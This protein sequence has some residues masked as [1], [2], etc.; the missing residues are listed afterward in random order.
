MN[1][2][3][4]FEKAIDKLPYN[5]LVTAS[6]LSP[7]GINTVCSLKNRVNKIVG[8]DI[9]GENTAGYFSDKFYTV[10]LAKD[11]NYLKRIL[12]ISK[13]EK[14]DAVFPLT[15]EELLVLSKNKDKLDKLKI[16]IIGETNYNVLRIC[17]D[18]WLTN[19]YLN[20]KGLSVPLACAPKSIKELMQNAKQLG[21]PGR[22]IVFKP[23]VTHGS[24]GFR[25]LAESYDKFDLLFNHKP[26]DNIF[27]SL[28]EL[29]DSLRY[30]KKLPMAMLMEYLEGEDY[31]VYL[32]CEKGKSLA[33]VPMRRAGLIPGMSTGG[34][35]QKDNQI[36]SYVKNIVK[37][38]SLSGPINIQLIKT[39]KG[40]RLYEINARISA[41]TVMTMGTYLN[42]PFLSVL[43]AF[44]FH[45][46][47]YSL[48]SNTEI[49]W[50]SRLFRI[51]KEIFQDGD[52][53]FWISDS[54]VGI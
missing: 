18:K 29:I 20:Q 6:G 27:L 40:P 22:K 52:G 41:T 51:Q 32:F 48:I 7:V 49:R 53:R 30:A 47:V 11:R 34:I 1:N 4:N 42:Y 9:D 21:Y 17:N 43:Q 14:I 23:R 8:V 37:A 31:S 24:R 46:K 44:G 45:Q 15:I 36:I 12:M 5:I 50:D 19:K 13:K 28:E 2:H 16:K 39:K 33:V 38:L 3:P 26:T 35:I 10:P 54:Q 25:I